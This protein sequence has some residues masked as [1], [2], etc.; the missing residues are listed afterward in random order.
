MKD[1]LA[2]LPEHK[3]AEIKRIADIIKDVVNPEMIILFGSYAKG[4]FVEHTYTNKE[5]TR[6]DYISDYDFLVV[7]RNNVDNAA[8]QE[9]QIVNIADQYNPSVNL[10]IHDVEYIDKGLEIGEY[11]FVDIIKE[12]IVLYDSG[13]VVFAEPRELSFFE[14]REKAERYFDV[15]FPQG[16]EFILGSQFFAARKNFKLAAFNLHQAAENLYCT[17]LLVF[18]SYK[19]KT[20]NLWKLR[21]KAKP[22]SEA[23]YTVFYAENDKNEKKLFEL[24]KR[25]YLDARYRIPDYDI[26]ED[27]LNTLIIRVLNMARIIEEL[28]KSHIKALGG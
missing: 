25:G 14:K 7:T 11:F 6:Y 4:T 1:S 2:H 28:C 9:S 12:G 5:G 15:W 13:R 3:Q 10:E 8:S 17:V 18:T 20:H 22:Y 21:A 26:T 24:L 23:L 27:E 16:N 19:P